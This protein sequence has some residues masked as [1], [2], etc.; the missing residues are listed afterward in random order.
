MAIP[1]ARDFPTL[2]M[3]RLKLC[4]GCRSSC[5][6]FYSRKLS[7]SC[8]ATAA[9]MHGGKKN[10]SRSGQSLTVAA[11]AAVL[12]DS[13]RLRVFTGL[14]THGFNRHVSL[15]SMIVYP[16]TYMCKITNP[17]FFLYLYGRYTKHRVQISVS[18]VFD[19]RFF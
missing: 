12:N 8:R 16:Y 3:F 4:F 6:I 1:V 14:G 19:V 9:R 10:G 2:G 11:A 15:Y 13:D 7:R 17:V 5:W 18:V